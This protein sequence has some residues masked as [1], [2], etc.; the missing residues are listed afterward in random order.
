VSRE[1]VVTEEVAGSVVAM[2][3]DINMIFAILEEFQELESDMAE[4]TLGAE[5][6]VFEK[7]AEVGKHMKPMFIKGHMGRKPMGWMMVDSGA[8]VNIM[9]LDVFRKLGHEEKDLKKTNLSLSGFSGEPATVRGVVSIE[10]TVGSKTIP[11]T[12]FCGGC[13]RKIQHASRP[14]LD[15]CQR[16]C[17]I[18]PSPMFNAEGRRSC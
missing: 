13:Q 17:A 3:M 14:G 11:T 12:F 6:A 7:L 18:Y 4:P 8:S 9:S 5:R 1:E 15:T 2:T 10:L 16:M